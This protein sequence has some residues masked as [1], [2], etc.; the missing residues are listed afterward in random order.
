M[1]STCLSHDYRT[2]ALNLELRWRWRANWSHLRPCS[3]R[4]F[5]LRSTR[6]TH[7]GRPPTC[8]S[9]PSR[10]P[11][12]VSIWWTSSCCRSSN[13]SRWPSWSTA[14]CSKR[15]TWAPTATGSVCSPTSGASSWS[16][17]NQHC[18]FVVSC[19]AFVHYVN[20]LFLMLFVIHRFKVSYC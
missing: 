19:Y 4:K 8:A 2:A 1:C 20:I 3:G 14:G 15:Y 12:L 10:C 5:K 11:P 7:C 13:R 9:C 18:T 6:W 17:S 16:P